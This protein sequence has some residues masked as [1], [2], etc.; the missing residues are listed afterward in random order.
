MVC[1][2]ILM[3][4]ISCSKSPT[5]ILFEERSPSSSGVTFANTLHN[6]TDL[7]I[8]NY[9]YYYNG[10][11]VTIGDFNN[12]GLEDLYFASN[13]DQDQLYLNQGNLT[14]TNVTAQSHINNNGGW[15]TGVTHVDINND[16]LLDIYICKVSGHLDLK[17]HNLLYV[18]QGVKNGVPSFKEEAAAFGLAFR[19]YATQATFFDYDLDGDLDM[20][21]MNHST[22][23][24][25]NYGS[26]NQRTLPNQ[27]SGDRLYE[28]KDG[29]YE[30]VSHQAGIYQGKIGYGLGLSIGDVN[31]DGWPDIY[32]GNDFFE[33]DYLY[34][35]NKDKTFTELITKNQMALGHTSHFS[36]GN[37]IADYNNDAQPDLFSLDMLPENLE[38]YKS[39]G[40]EY[41]YTTYANYLNNGYAPQYMQNTLHLNL[42][43]NRFSEIAALCGIQATEWS[44]SIL[45]ADFDNDGLKDSYITN[46]I[47]GATNDM[48]FINFIANDNIQK[49]LSNGTS[50]HEMAF[51][52]RLPSKKVAN[53]FFRNKGD[54][55]FENTTA[56]WT[57]AKPSYSNGATYADL[58]NDGDLEIVVNN[59]NENAYI[60]KNLTTEK[61]GHHYLTIRL[62]GH[63]S[64]PFGVGTHIT[65]FVGNKLLTLDN[66]NTK[67]YLSTTTNTLTLGLGKSTMVDS[68]Q[69]TWP[70]GEIQ[71][72]N[73]IEVDQSITLH[74]QDAK[75]SN[76]PLNESPMHAAIK[77]LPFLHDDRSSV[78]FYRDPLVPFANTN[79]GPMASVA[80]I[81]KDG[82]QDIFVCGAKQQASALLLQGP[83][84]TFEKVQQTLFE[85]NATAEDVSHLFFDA[86]NDGFD[87]LVVVSGGN[88]FQSGPNLRP[89]MYW[90]RAG[91][92]EK[93]T[94]NFINCQTNASAVKTWDYNN[95]GHK[96]LVITSDQVPW[97]F[98]KSPIHYVFKNNGD[99]T[100][101]DVTQ[102]MATDLNTLG[103]IK[104]IAIVDLDQNGFQDLVAV[105]H[106]MPISIVHNYNGQ[107]K[108]KE[109]PGLAMSHGLWNTL[110]IGDFDNDGDMDIIAGNWGT[111]SKLKA[112]ATKPM[113]LYRTDL[114][115]NGTIE[116][117]VTYFHGETETP[118]ASKDELT[119]QIPS[120]NKKFLTYESFAKATIHEL[121]PEAKRQKAL[122]KKVYELR[123]SFFENMGH[124][125][126]VIRPLPHLAQV[127]NVFDILVEDTN[128]DH[129]FVL[130]GNNYEISTQ[131][132]RMDAS[133][134]LILRTSKNDLNVINE[135]ETLGVQG[136][137]RHISTLE[138]DGLSGYLVSRNNDSLLF[139][140][141]KNP[142]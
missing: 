116:T 125:D 39:S 92:F 109:Y 43:S 38:T 123:S 10:A 74:F 94:L 129:N 6:G 47:L 52:E 89:R 95:D 75:K 78:E 2:G 139:I 119:K 120:L 135:M 73:D 20:Y 118:F 108:R 46:G 76:A 23:P 91:I 112:S 107:L 22:A 141:K 140:S 27:V 29:I 51:I 30:D 106:W 138:M 104:D 102:S 63:E 134:G 53:Y 87:D 81:N 12:D 128:G 127:S 24:N 62:K 15:T 19:G 77:T 34:I 13:Q 26:G 98:G 136:A 113:S 9:I 79:Q 96:D 8:L 5:A 7:N 58:D 86:N 54:L 131:L 105:G 61:L 80:D 64:N 121:L 37:A 59:I 132:G 16:G 117:V 93:D 60:L 25:A 17:G 90:N 72:L 50:N 66:F 18:N 31:Q 49:Q 45:V 69:V 97:E 57:H 133:H 100:F 82:L 41:P 101:T 68:L 83:R 1:T 130:V 32:V 124:E 137:S 85:E 111:N 35:N 21:L 56:T 122:H 67:G 99:E 28:N 42:G 114:D 110:K 65:A 103:N 126:F 3:G 14:F 115:D 55:T 11:G 33:N 70:T 40:N 84:G 142:K 44:W 88:E 36:M 71:M 4:F 48:D